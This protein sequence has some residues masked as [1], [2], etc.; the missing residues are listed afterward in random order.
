M[1]GGIS[2]CKD[3]LQGDVANT[4]SAPAHDEACNQG[5]RLLT[6]AQGWPTRPNQGSRVSTHSSSRGTNPSLAED[7]AQPRYPMQ[8]TAQATTHNSRRSRSIGTMPYGIEGSINNIVNSTNNQQLKV[9]DRFRQNPKRE[10]LRCWKD[11]ARKVLIDK[12]DNGLAAE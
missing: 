1:G 2:K 8:K 9:C 6:A 7:I 5:R 3:A 10:K 11:H 12:V 4:T